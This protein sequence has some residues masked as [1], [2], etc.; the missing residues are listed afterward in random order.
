LH[1]EKS[2]NVRSELR[3]FRKSD[4]KVLTVG[5]LMLWF[6][7]GVVVKNSRCVFVPLGQYFLAVRATFAQ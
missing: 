1:F 2:Q 5:K 4:E 3:D 7:A 6:Y